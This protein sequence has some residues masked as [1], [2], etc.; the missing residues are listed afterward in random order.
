MEVTFRSANN[1]GRIVD[2]QEEKDQNRA[3][4]HRV[5]CHPLA[6]ILSLLNRTHVDYFSLDVEGHELAVLKTIPFDRLDVTTLSVE[7]THVGELDGKVSSKSQ[8]VK[9]MKSK[10]YKVRAKVTHY[11]NLANDFI[12]VKRGF[13]E[14]VALENLQD[15]PNNS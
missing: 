1:I 9:F 3:K 8:M 6:K 2:G 14:D 7:F 15:L 5:I 13:N 12:F 10:G 4:L 11:N